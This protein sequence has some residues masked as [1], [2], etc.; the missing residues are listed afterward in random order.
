MNPVFPLFI[1]TQNSAVEIAAKNF[2]SW[3][4][5]M[6]KPKYSEFKEK[7]LDGRGLGITTIKHC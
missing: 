6:K 7:L 5:L 4:K 1:F 3:S 2:N